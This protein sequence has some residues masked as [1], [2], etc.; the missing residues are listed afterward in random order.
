MEK[1]IEKLFKEIENQELDPNLLNAALK[2]AHPEVKFGTFIIEESKAISFGT[3]SAYM[4]KYDIQSDG[5]SMGQYEC[6]FNTAHSL[7]DENS[8]RLELE[9]LIRFK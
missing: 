5:Q 3:V 8:Y 1:D 7:D 6:R 4:I 2:R 9:Q